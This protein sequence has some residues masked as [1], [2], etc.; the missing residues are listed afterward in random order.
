MTDANELPRHEKNI[1]G[2][3]KGYGGCKRC[4]DTW[5]WKQPHDTPINARQGC[6]PLCQECWEALT[7]EQ[8]LPYYERLADE[9]K[10][11][12]SPGEWPDLDADMKCI[13]QAVLEGK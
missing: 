13:R 3:R 8:R 11:L 4:H 2:R 12:S 10:S 1:R 6:F 7:P 9:W 5:D